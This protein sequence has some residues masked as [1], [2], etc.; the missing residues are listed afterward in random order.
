MPKAE[1]AG[2]ESCLVRYRPAADP[3]GM[4]EIAF[5]SAHTFR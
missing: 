5:T 4:K 3:L 2:T 1:K